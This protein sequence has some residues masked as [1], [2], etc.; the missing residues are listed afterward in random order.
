MCIR[1][2]KKIAT[3]LSLHKLAFPEE[4][5]HQLAQPE[6]LNSL[7]F[8][9]VEIACLVFSDSKASRVYQ[10]PPALSESKIYSLPQTERVGIL[11]KW[12]KSLLLQGKD[13]ICGFSPTHATLSKEEGLK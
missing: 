12:Y 11:D 10:V 1:K 9:P 8:M 13:V 4:N 7:N 3:S 6:T 5:P 2:K